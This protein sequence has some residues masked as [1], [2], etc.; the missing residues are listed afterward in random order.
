[1]STAQPKRSVRF[2]PFPS[3]SSVLSS[4]ITTPPPSPATDRGLDILQIGEEFVATI[5][6]RGEDET[7]SSSLD[8]GRH[9]LDEDSLGSPSVERQSR[10]G[11][12]DF[13]GDICFIVR[14][15]LRHRYNPN[16]SLT[17]SRS[18]TT[19]S[20]VTSRP[21]S[22]IGEIVI[23]PPSPE[24][25]ALHSSL[26]NNVT[27]HEDAP[28]FSSFL[29]LGGD[30]DDEVSA[31]KS[32]VLSYKPASEASSAMIT[33]R[34]SRI[35]LSRSLE[36]LKQVVIGRASVDVSKALPEIITHLTEQVE[37]VLKYG[38]ELENE[39]DSLN[40]ELER[41][42]DKIKDYAAQLDYAQQ[43]HKEEVHKLETD[44]NKLEMELQLR[45]SEPSSRRVVTLLYPESRSSV[46]SSEAATSGRDT[47]LGD[48]RLKERVE[49][50]EAENRRLQGGLEDADVVTE[51]LG[52]LK[53][54]NITLQERNS[55]LQVE[56]EKHKEECRVMAQLNEQYKERIRGLEAAQ[57]NHAKEMEDLQVD[58]EQEKM[59]QQ[60]GTQPLSELLPISS[61]S[62]SG[63]PSRVSALELKVMKCEGTEIISGKKR[64]L[65][66]HT[67]VSE[68]NVQ[69]C[70]EEVVKRP[71]AGL[72][73]S[74]T[75]HCDIGSQ[76]RKFT[77]TRCNCET[78]YIETEHSALI[79]TKCIQA[80]EPTHLPG[81][82]P[83]I[84]LYKNHAVE[85]MSVTLACKRTTSKLPSLHL[86][87][88]P[89]PLN[90][91]LPPEAG[92]EESAVVTLSSSPSSA[93]RGKRQKRW[94]SMSSTTFLFTPGT[95]VGVQTN[96]PRQ[97]TL[98]VSRGY[99]VHIM[100]IPDEVGQSDGLACSYLDQTNASEPR[101]SVCTQGIAESPLASPP[102]LTS[103]S[104]SVEPAT[105]SSQTEVAPKSSLIEVASPSQDYTSSVGNKLQHPVATPHLS[106]VSTEPQKATTDARIMSLGS[107]QHP[108]VS[109]EALTPMKGMPPL[110]T[111][112]M[113]LATPQPVPPTR[114]RVMS[115]DPREHADSHITTHTR[116]TSCEPRT[117]LASYSGRSRTAQTAIHR[118]HS[119]STQPPLQVRSSP[120]DAA[121]AYI[122]PPQSFRALK[123]Q[124]PPCSPPFISRPP[125][126]AAQTPV[127]RITLSADA[128]T[129]P[130]MSRISFPILDPTAPRPTHR[131]TFR[132]GPDISTVS[133]S[134]CTHQGCCHNIIVPLHV[135]VT[136]C[137]GGPPR[138]HS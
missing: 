112:V 110:H 96:N 44:I 31:F 80:V 75:Q 71:K 37:D 125:I 19:N 137:C 82:K 91:P 133:C 117:R 69:P 64:R 111:R 34:F 1:M 42:Q 81:L 16:E 30:H 88:D 21:D 24:D 123:C 131:G 95:C 108:I 28:N 49:E 39:V 76:L 105:T 126:K 23:C 67:R 40:L 102:P 54:T 13:S 3:G 41:R 113:P 97:R 2:E 98:Q 65:A 128:H 26:F 33:T 73:V 58:L 85:I 72:H 18:Q 115:L 14:P 66:W 134:G 103:P 101:T 68:E 45:H 94:S 70:L 15:R 27:L 62:F 17:S 135:T 47:S 11:S 114:A 48:N 10:G 84:G 56:L 99:I 124:S 50:L 78:V 12:V 120:A 61:A 127:T 83:H 55:A 89:G 52:T 57:K 118:A 7:A 87:P 9:P 60:L 119:L 22:P 35:E 121:N 100:I 74:E 38:D 29:S 132:C 25:T 53:R 20:P 5:K 36:R 90:L 63:W 104:V 86:N 6:A 129:T 43:L 109:K 130:C 106:I 93:F 107:R 136:G 79:S 59:K 4:S 77:C 116:I 92:S 8:S 51:E 46:S 122:P 138:Y 32:E